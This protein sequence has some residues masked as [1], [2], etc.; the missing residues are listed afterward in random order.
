MTRWNRDA[1]TQG[2]IKIAD[3][4]STAVAYVW[5]GDV[6]KVKTYCGKRQKPD[7]YYRFPQGRGAA[8]RAIK[9]YFEDVQANEKTKADYKNRMDAEADQVEVGGIYYTSWGYDQTNIDYYQVVGRTAKMVKYIAIGK[10]IYDT[11][12]PAQDICVADPMIKGKEIHTAKIN[13]NGWRISSFEFARAWNGE[14]NKQT[15]RGYGH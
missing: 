4:H 12:C 10:S 15:A 7:G 9:A 1:D 14:P 6:P 8:G 3:K 5:P 13:G 11:D 2:A